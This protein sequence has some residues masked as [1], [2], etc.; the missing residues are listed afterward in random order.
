MA[1]ARMLAI[2]AAQGATLTQVDA[3]HWSINSVDGLTHDIITLVG[4][5]VYQ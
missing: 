4:A 1:T 5:T 2:T 3:R